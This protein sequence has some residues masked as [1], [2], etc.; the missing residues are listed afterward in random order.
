MFRDIYTNDSNTL[1]VKI[2][3]VHGHS[4]HYGNDEAD[5]VTKS[6][7]VRLDYDDIKWG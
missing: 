4:D 5:R 2:S 1:E 7:I 3:C 6:G